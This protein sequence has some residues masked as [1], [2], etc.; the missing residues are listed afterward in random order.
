MRG[1]NGKGESMEGERVRH[2]ANTG[3]TAPGVYGSLGL[4]VRRP[5]VYGAQLLRYGARVRGGASSGRG[6]GSGVSFLWMAV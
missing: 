6:G 4:E 1:E 5:H 2:E 3:S